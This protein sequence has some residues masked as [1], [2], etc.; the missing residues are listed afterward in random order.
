MYGKSIYGE[1]LYG[2]PLNIDI[3]IDDSEDTYYTDI[4]RYMPEYITE[5]D[6][7][8]AIYES[9]GYELGIL[10]HYISEAENQCYIDT[11]TWGITRWE[12]VY[13][14]ASNESLS[15]SERRKVV[16]SLIGAGA[17]TTAD[18]IEKLAYQITG[19]NASVKE[20]AAKYNFTVFFYGTYGIP[21]NV[22]QFAK[23]IEKIIP[24]HLTY[25]LE[26]RYTT[27]EEMGKKAWGE[28]AAYTWEG[29]RM[30]RIIPFTS[31]GDVADSS[32][33]SIRQ[34]SWKSIKKIEEVQ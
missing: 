22:L 18:L 2:N 27:W 25:T 14:V 32:W 29:I 21:K 33:K 5:F 15:I 8:N 28:S 3:D 26:Y 13:G 19:T 30:N 4:E 31:W 7:M 34:Y 9:Q 1:S 6:E 12:E 11:T 10:W 16:K 24:A 20:E 23:M 17:V